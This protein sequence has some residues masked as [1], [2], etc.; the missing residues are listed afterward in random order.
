MP[1]AGGTGIV[2]ALSVSYPTKP[3]RIHAPQVVIA[4]HG[5]QVVQAS[6]Q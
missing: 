6:Q 4:L 2:T 1:T 3:S 5:L